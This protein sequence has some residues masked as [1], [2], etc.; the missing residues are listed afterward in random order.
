MDIGDT[1]QDMGNGEDATTY[2][3]QTRPRKLPHDLPMSLDD[4]RPVRT[5]AGETEM[6]DAWQ[7]MGVSCYAEYVQD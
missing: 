6:Y 7:G 4:R 2:E 3:E 5:Y 1:Y